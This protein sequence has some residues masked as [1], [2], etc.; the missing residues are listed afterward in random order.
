[1]R[2]HLGQTVQQLDGRKATLS[3]GSS[4]EADVVVVGVGVSPSVALAENAGLAMDRGVS[5]DQYLQTSA[6]GVCR[7]RYRALARSIHRGSYPR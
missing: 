5:V 4:L 3:D 1:M 2:F 6:P 7:R